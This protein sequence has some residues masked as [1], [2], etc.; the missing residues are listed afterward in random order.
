MTWVSLQPLSFSTL[1]MWSV[2]KEWGTEAVGMSRLIQGLKRR[3]ELVA[4]SLSR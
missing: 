2:R 4:G 1:A 3:R